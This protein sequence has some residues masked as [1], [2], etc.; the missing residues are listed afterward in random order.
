[1]IAYLFNFFTLLSQKII[2]NRLFSLFLILPR[3]EIN[4]VVSQN[5]R[6][7]ET[8]RPLRL[9]AQVV[10]RLDWASESPDELKR[11]GPSLWIFTLTVHGM[12]LLNLI[13]KFLFSLTPLGF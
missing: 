11:I 10:H 7:G 13:F 9:L 4:T 6:P 3:L 8:S 5:I 1:M 12:G 2:E